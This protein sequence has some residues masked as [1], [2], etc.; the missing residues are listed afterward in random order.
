MKKIVKPLV[1]ILIIAAV[2]S[3]C[4]VFRG[5]LVDTLRGAIG[6]LRGA[7]SGE[8][9]LHVIDVGQGDAILIRSDD[10]AVLV[11]TGTYD[12]RGA[13]AEY[14]RANNAYRIDCLIITHPHADHIGGAEYIVRN[15][16]VG[17]VM[18]CD[19]DS[20]SASLTRLLTAVDE[21][22]IRLTEPS[23][24][25][26]TEVGD[27]TFRVLSPLP[28]LDTASNDGSIVM[29][30]EWG[31]TAFMLTG[32]AETPAEELILENYPPE[33]LRCDFLKL[34]HHGSSTSTSGKFLDAVSPGWVAI[35]C[36]KDN[37]YGHPHREVLERL[38]GFGLDD[39][40]ILRTDR[41]GSVVF[42][43]DGREVRFERQYDKAA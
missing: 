27:I 31:S 1:S 40:H 6:M 37:D 24:G 20:T 23:V 36:G 35:S 15:F 19:S 3:V 39:E 7:E 38:R 30:V 4:F 5:E 32:D 28:G 12:S 43:S 34:G 18:L 13:L 25:S 9:E 26:L 41:D 29:R 17:C 16:K 21:L 33:E 42:V 10:A 11:D 8:L 2:L 14:L 22:G